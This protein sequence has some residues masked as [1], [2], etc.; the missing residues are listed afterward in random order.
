MLFK[1][2]ESCP[3]TTVA[4]FNCC[5]DH[6]PPMVQARGTDLVLLISQAKVEVSQFLEPSSSARS[7]ILILHHCRAAMWPVLLLSFSLNPGW[8]F[9]QAVW[10]K[11][12]SRLLLP[13][14]LVSLPLALCLNPTWPP[15]VLAVPAVQLFFHPDPNPSEMP[16]VQIC[17]KMN[18]TKKLVSHSFVEHFC[19]C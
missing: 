17:P 12:L 4:L 9:T 6:P 15:L 2:A 1:I 10:S 8:L 16:W 14:F 13:P 19:L 5:G 7:L 18:F 3:E 11:L